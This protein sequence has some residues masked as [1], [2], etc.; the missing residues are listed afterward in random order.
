VKTTNFNLT[1]AEASGLY[2]W[3]DAAAKAFFAAAE[4]QAYLNSFSQPVAPVAKPSAVAAEEKV[5][6]KV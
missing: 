6:A 1:V 2:D 4:Q 5:T 3:G